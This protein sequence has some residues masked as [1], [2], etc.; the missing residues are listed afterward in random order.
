MNCFEAFL[1]IKKSRYIQISEELK[2]QTGWIFTNQ[3]SEDL[4][5]WMIEKYGTQLNL[6]GE[7]GEIL[8]TMQPNSYLKFIEYYNGKNT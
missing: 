1:I 2:K 8:R 7:E 5:K 6:C 3:N 4:Y